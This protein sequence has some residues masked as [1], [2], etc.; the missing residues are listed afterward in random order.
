MITNE[1]VEAAFNMFLEAG[2]DDLIDVDT[3]R[4]ALEAAESVS[5]ITIRNI[6]I[7]NRYDELRSSG[8]HGHYETM[9]Q[10]VREELE[11]ARKTPQ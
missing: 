11:L 5:E 8:K 4:A 10:V 9:F 3:V 1:M 2:A 6:R 7:Q